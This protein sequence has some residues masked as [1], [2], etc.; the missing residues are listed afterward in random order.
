[1]HL[2]LHC[3]YQF[4]L[5]GGR[6]PLIYDESDDGQ[7]RYID[8]AKTAMLKEYDLMTLCIRAALTASKPS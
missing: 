3:T 5:Y 1:M 2:V 7:R 6:L 4:S 8:A